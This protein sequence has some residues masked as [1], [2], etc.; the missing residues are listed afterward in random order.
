[1]N[2]FLKISKKI[3]TNAYESISKSWLSTEYSILIM[4]IILLLN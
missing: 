1:M 4:R 2:D 3:Q